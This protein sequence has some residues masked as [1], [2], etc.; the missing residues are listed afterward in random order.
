M[1]KYKI[2]NEDINIKLEN[3]ERKHGACYT[4]IENRKYPK[5]ENK[6]IQCSIF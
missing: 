6:F 1:R 3:R 5:T 4:T 2:Y